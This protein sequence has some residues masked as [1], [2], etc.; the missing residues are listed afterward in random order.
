MPPKKKTKNKTVQKKSIN[1]T[2]KVNF[3][4]PVPKIKITVFGI[5]GGGSSIVSE[6]APNFKKVN[7]VAAN[8]DKGALAKTSDKVKRFQFG[9]KVTKGFGTG[10]DFELGKIAAAADKEKI[11]RIIEGQD[12]CI[13]IV[14]LGGGAGSGG[15]LSF[16]KIAKELGCISYGIF[17]LP[18]NFEGTKKMEIAKQAIEEVSPHLNAIT[19]LP[20]ENIFKVIS[21]ETPFKDA[22]SMVNK[23]LSQNLSGLIGTI[24]NSG[25]INID[26]ADLKTIMEGRGRIAYLNVV[27]VDSNKNK[28]DNFATLTSSPFYS[29]NAKGARGIILNIIGG[30]EIGMKFV[31]DIS[32]T[33]SGFCKRNAKFV[34]GISHDKNLKNKNEIV[35]F[36]VGCEC[37]FGQKAS[38]KKK[39]QKKEKVLSKT[40]E[41]SEEKKPPVPSKP[42]KKKKINAPKEEKTNIKVRRNAIEIK[43]EL[44]EAEKEILAEEK[45]WEAPAFLRRKTENNF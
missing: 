42:F 19:I 12:V 4:E 11:K 39:T 44:E 36:A 1:K 7:F 17:T 30:K 37:D 26:F 33:V 5:G 10:M 18:F 35:L 16:A 31:S 20:N 27:S 15:V 22:L 32:K 40:K 29:Y 23:K 13:F 28:D 2:N 45:K 3:N 6:I 34:L 14:S 43:K 24:S 8:T 25:L 21:K 38:P 9:E 41:E